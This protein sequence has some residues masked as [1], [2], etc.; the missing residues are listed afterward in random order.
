MTEYIAYY[1]ARD[2]RNQNSGLARVVASSR[3]EAEEKL[4][5]VA[6]RYFPGRWITVYAIARDE[7]IPFDDPA[8]ASIKPIP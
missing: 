4:V 7:L 2:Y 3:G 8:T 5:T 1:I 6:Q